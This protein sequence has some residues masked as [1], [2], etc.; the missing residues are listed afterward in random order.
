MTRAVILAC[1]PWLAMFVVSLLAMCL[2]VRVGQARFQLGRLLRLHADEGGSAQTLSFVLTLPIFVWIMLFIVQVSQIMIGTVVV[3]YAAYAAARSASVWIPAYLSPDEP[4]NCISTLALDPQAPDQ[5]VPSVVVFGQPADGPIGGGVTFLVQPG[6][7]KYNIIQSAA[8]LACMPIS[9]ARNVGLNVSG[10]AAATSSALKAVYA[11]MIPSSQGNSMIP[12]CLDNKLAYAAANTTVE[13]RFFHK[14]SVLD[15]PLQPYPWLASNDTPFSA[16]YGATEFAPN[17]LGWQD[18]ITVTVKY[19]F[20][21][22]PGTG[23]ILSSIAGI[24]SP[25]TPAAMQQGN[26]YAYLLV[27]EATMG[28]EGEKSMVSYPYVYPSN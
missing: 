27:A 18:Q 13:L 2:V 22:L 11:A 19:Y 8:V 15:P 20:P 26:V 28:N 12:V 16:S 5:T 3:H 7:P 6:S 9:P 25:G 10:Q 21:L 24:L 23:R 17:E 14:N 4:E 1:L